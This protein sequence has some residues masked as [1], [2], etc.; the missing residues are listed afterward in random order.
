MGSLNQGTTQCC[1][2]FLVL[3]FDGFV[4]QADKPATK[5]TG[6]ERLEELGFFGF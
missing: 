3:D 1:Q 2:A 4:L 5:L 6:D